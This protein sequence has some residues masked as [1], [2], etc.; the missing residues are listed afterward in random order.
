[1][2][3][4][5]ASALIDARPASVSAPWS[6]AANAQQTIANDVEN[7]R[8][9]KGRPMLTSQ[10]LFA[11][12]ITSRTSFTLAGSRCQGSVSLFQRLR[13]ITTTHLRVISMRGVE[14]GVASSELAVHQL[15]AALDNYAGG[16]R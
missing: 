2:C 16:F 13:Q 14:E 5:S 6:T 11:A 7:L 9:V 15:Q 4:F 10:R 1:M 8:S 3:P 12:H